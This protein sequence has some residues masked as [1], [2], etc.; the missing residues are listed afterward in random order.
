MLFKPSQNVNRKVLAICFIIL[1]T[2][3]WFFVV[4]IM[5]GRFLDHLNYELFS[6]IML[7]CYYFSV[8]LFSLIGLI[9]SKKISTTTLF[10]I[11][12]TLG[13]FSSFLLIPLNEYSLSQVI[14]IALILGASLGI[15][16]PSCLAKF[17]DL[18]IISKRG[19]FAGLTFSM[20][21]FAVFPF[22]ILVESCSLLVNSVILFI[23]RGTSLLA[24]T[25]LSKDEFTRIETEYPDLLS[26]KFS[27]KALVLYF[28]VW[29]LFCMVDRFEAPVLVSFFGRER[30]RLLLLIESV[31]GSLS[32][33][34]GGLLCDRIGRKPIII[35][36][37][38][39]LGLAY[40]ILGIFPTIALSSYLYCLADGVSGGFLLTIFVLIIWGDLSSTVSAEIYYFIGNTPYFAAE[41]F[42][43]LFFKEKL[44]PITVSFS[45][46]SF[47]LF[48]AVIPLL[49]APETLPEKIIR[50]RELKRYI[51]KAKKI[52]E[53]YEK[54]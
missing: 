44:V 15:G 36:G 25:A 39:S 47:F 4:Q 2:F 24:I 32:A 16:L 45:L 23:W 50:R 46:A 27:N 49:Y 26:T 42:R 8:I 53:K 21:N 38:I 48:I 3:T 5:I 52:R 12:I 31:I 19:F 51:E 17:S 11:W 9:F 33:V 37:F 14:I 29:L 10:S 7:S 13:A 43:I 1:N 41:I 30:Y 34:V 54:Q 40:A 28:I 22:A 18:T 6:N 20:A 35:Y